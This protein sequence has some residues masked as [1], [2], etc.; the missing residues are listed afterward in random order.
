MTT[1]QTGASKSTDG[2]DLI[3]KYNTGSILFCLIEQISNS[4]GSHANEHFHKVGS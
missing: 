3:N 4:A 1:A 2:I